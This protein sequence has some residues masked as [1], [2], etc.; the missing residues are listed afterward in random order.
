MQ[1]LLRLHTHWQVLKPRDCV[2]M[3]IIITGLL[4]VIVDRYRRE[5]VADA[6]AHGE[7][8]AV[9]YKELD[10]TDGDVELALTGGPSSASE[11]PAASGLRSTASSMA[12]EGHVPTDAGMLVA[13]AV[14][15]ASSEPRTADARNH[16]WQTGTFKDHALGPLI[17]ER[18]V[19]SATALVG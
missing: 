16:S 15:S 7:Y 6:A 3:V 8:A 19:K 11:S 2:A 17:P 1:M 10:G 14:P 9:S 18:E 12:A 4:I 5:R 13:T